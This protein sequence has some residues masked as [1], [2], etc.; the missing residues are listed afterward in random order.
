MRTALIGAFNVANVLAA[1]ATARLA[2]YDTEV[3]AAGLA[4]PMR[5]PGRMEPI[6]T[7]RPFLVFVDYAHTP[8]ALRAALAA[9]RTFVAPASRL[10]VV[11]GCGGDRD[12]AKRP[13]MGAVATQMS[14]VA[15]LT[16][17]N[18]RSED[19][20]AIAREVLADISAERPAPVV[21]LDRRRAIRLA[22]RAAAAGDVV[23]IAGK[24]HESGQTAHGVTVPFDDRVV[25]REELEA[26]V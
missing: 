15:Y 14:D 16:S 13:A 5:V 17:D 2:G 22:L 19:P 25:A 23:V 10:L 18:P 3:I 26:H 7:G 4:A 21:E 6:A 1:Y 8:E 20:H 12:R 11:F 9:A 24:G